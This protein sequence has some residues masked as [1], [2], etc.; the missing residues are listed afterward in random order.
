[1]VLD[2]EFFK[3]MEVV[4]EE[5]R[6]DNKII[7]NEKEYEII[8]YISIDSGNFIAYTDGK[9]LENGQIALYVNRVSQENE[10][11]IFDEV[12]D[13]EVMQVIN[14]LKERLVSNE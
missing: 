14:A 11:V 9:H 7:I 3:K 12:E 1:M 13:E 2:R 10:E 4:M 8:S 5:E 6:K